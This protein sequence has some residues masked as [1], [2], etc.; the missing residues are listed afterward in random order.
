MVSDVV[1]GMNRFMNEFAAK[2]LILIFG[3]TYWIYGCMHL[4]DLLL[5]VLYITAMIMAVFLF[6]SRSKYSFNKIVFFLIALSALGTIISTDNRKI[7]VFI[8]IYICIEVVVLANCSEGKDERALKKELSIISN[9]FMFMSL[10]VVAG[11]LYTYTKGIS[12]YYSYSEIMNGT[13][14]LGIDK[15]TGALVG[16]F[17]NANALSSFLVQAI[18]LKLYMMNDKRHHFLS[19]C[20]IVLLLGTLYLTRSRG[21]LIGA[22]IV[23]VAYYFSCCRKYFLKW[24]AKS[25]FVI[26]MIIGI[27]IIALL[28]INGFGIE[29]IVKR[30]SLEMGRSTASRQFLWSAGIRTVLSD[31][32][33]FI[34]GVGGNIR[35]AISMHIDPTVSRNLYSNMHNIYIQTAVEFGIL[36]LILL[37]LMFMRYVINSMK[38]ILENFGENNDLMP[39]AGLLVSLT[40]MSFVESDLYMGK[41]FLS[42]LFW[43]VGGYVYR[44]LILRKTRGSLQY[45]SNDIKYTFESKELQI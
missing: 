24:S 12:R 23:F 29:K 13:L 21:G 1:L 7:T 17:S 28:V 38:M 8:L 10:I 26:L 6:L 18:G 9:V 39:L 34:F 45:K 20:Y 43:I 2:L 42:T 27:G 31:P 30:D 14:V 22:L 36:G 19:W 4:S 44:I 25:L 15:V 37:L 40:V 33:I 11:T 41:T 35:E 3:I 16:I 5:N 32:M